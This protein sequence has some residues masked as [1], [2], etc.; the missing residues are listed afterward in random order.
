MAEKEQIIDGAL[1]FMS[2]PGLFWNQGSIEIKKRVQ[3]VIFPEGLSYDC[4]D[5][6]GTA[7]LNE[8]YQLIRKIAP[9]GDFDNIMVALMRNRLNPQIV[10]YIH[11]RS[12]G[13]NAQSSKV[14]GS[15]PAR[16]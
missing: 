13:G 9:E 2:D 7:K 4:K 8:S 15:R 10:K 12:S 16:P 6:F 1:L 3:D 11:K 5:G 14:G